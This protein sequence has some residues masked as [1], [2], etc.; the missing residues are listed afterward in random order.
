MA[1]PLH[2]RQELNEIA[3]KRNKEN[4]KDWVPSDQLSSSHCQHLLGSAP[5]KTRADQ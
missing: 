5:V 2:F 3:L 1:N 4:K